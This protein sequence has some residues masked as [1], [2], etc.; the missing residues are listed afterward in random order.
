MATLGRG[1]TVLLIA[2]LPLVAVGCN[3]DLA[4]EFAAAPA[5]T[6][7]G[8]DIGSATSLTL[9]NT[10][11]EPTVGP[12]EVTF[13]L[14]ADEFPSTDDIVLSDS[15][16]L[17]VLEAGATANASPASLVIP[18]GTL[19]GPQFLLAIVTDTGKNT[20]A[21]TYTLSAIDIEQ[22]PAPSSCDA[23]YNDLAAYHASPFPS[24][25]AR[26]L[27]ILPN[28]RAAVATGDGE[29]QSTLNGVVVGGAESAGFGP[30]GLLLRFQEDQSLDWGR[31]ISHCTADEVTSV[32]TFSDGT[33]AAAVTFK[34]GDEHLSEL[35]AYATTGE[36]LWIHP[37]SQCALSESN[38][39][40]ALPQV[41]IGTD[42]DAAVVAT[43]IPG[44]LLLVRVDRY[45][46]EL[47]RREH[48]GLGSVATDISVRRFG[49]TL[50]S[51]LLASVESITALEGDFE[52]RWS[53]PLTD[54]SFGTYLHPAP[55]VE[56]CDTDNF[57]VTTPG[58]EFSS[59]AHVLYHFSKAG[60]ERWG[61]R[62]LNGDRVGSAPT[63]TGP[64]MF[65]PTTHHGLRCHAQGVA[66]V[67]AVA[68]SEALAQSNEPRG[69]TFLN[70]GA[71]AYT[72]EGSWP[73][74]LLSGGG[75][76]GL[77]SAGLRFVQLESGK[78][79]LHPP[80]WLSWH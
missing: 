45:G 72:Y 46:N 50:S 57:F 6:C 30:R 47:L 41:T 33:V 11:T 76:I 23:Q 29:S 26:P 3:D 52:V 22:C 14:S 7:S 2:L 66:E 53:H 51:V 9:T 59:G 43:N 24:R 65:L 38:C 62:L 56:I 12:V 60:E 8:S 20:D 54:L 21:S 25:G 80:D 17:G 28:N 19:L 55:E 74:G 68:G 77:G 15:L 67:M 32:A 75:G 40:A 48:T 4:V 1:I 42:D 34:A 31:A 10:A 79:S 61:I 70:G 71:P 44:A 63:Y 18:S 64:N 16:S 36:L 27:T 49:S 37:L 69:V 13:A 39:M 58:T 78:F 5:I 35:R 73:S